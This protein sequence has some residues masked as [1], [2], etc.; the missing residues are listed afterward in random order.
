MS[1]IS[2]RTVDFGWGRKPIPE[3]L[4]NSGILLER[5]AQ[6]DIDADAICR[7]HIRGLLTDRERDNAIRRAVRRMQR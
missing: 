3:Q 7:L 2:R 1:D 4:A 5:L 6:A